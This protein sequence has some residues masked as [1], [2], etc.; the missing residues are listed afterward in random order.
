MK[1][2]TLL[3]RKPAMAVLAVCACALFASGADGAFVARPAS[4]GGPAYSPVVRSYFNPGFGYFG[5]T[6]PFLDFNTF[7]APYPYMPNYWWTGAYPTADPRQAGYNPSA[8]YRWED[9]TTLVLGTFPKR[10]DVTLDGSSIGS[11]EDLGPIQLPFGEHTVRVEAPGYEPS[12]TVVKVQAQSFQRLQ[13][14]LK[15]SGS[16]PRP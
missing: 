5:Y 2:L 9:V 4:G 8:G 6:S 14:N 11:A 12:E 3:L 15:P 13:V 1:H 16:Q 7:S 10:A